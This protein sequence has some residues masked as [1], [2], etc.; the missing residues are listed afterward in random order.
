MFWQDTTLRK[1]GTAA[2]V[3]R[4]AHLSDSHPSGSGVDEPLVNILSPSRTCSSVA[5]YRI[6]SQGVSLSHR[7]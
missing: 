1:S 5:H 4:D 3:G 2:W 6:S 7:A